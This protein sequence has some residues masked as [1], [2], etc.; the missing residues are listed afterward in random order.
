MILDYDLTSPSNQTLST[1]S[2]NWTALM[3]SDTHW[4]NHSNLSEYGN[5]YLNVTL[6]YIN[7]NGSLIQLDSYQVWIWV[8]G[9]GVVPSQAGVYAWQ[10]MYNLQTGDNV[11]WTAS[12]SC[13][14]LNATMFLDYEV[15]AP[16]GA[17]TSSGSI[18][19]TANLARIGPMC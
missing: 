2:W 13:L 6:S 7:A 10:S 8:D 15:R 9:C 4:V 1:G 16:S 14:V 5:Y 18:N 11:T 19:W 17:L 12:S 3:T